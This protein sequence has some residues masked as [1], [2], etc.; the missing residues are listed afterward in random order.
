MYC[1]DINLLFIH[2]T[3][4]SGTSIKKSLREKYKVENIAGINQH[5]RTALSYSKE[6]DLNNIDTVSI[7]RNPYDRYMSYLNFAHNKEWFNGNNFHFM[8]PQYEY[9]YSKD[10]CLVNDILKF[11]DRE[12]INN[13][14][15]KYDIKIYKH[16]IS[17]NKKYEY[18]N[19]D[20]IAFCNKMYDKDFKLFNYERIQL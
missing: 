1:K 18:L 9:L 15:N 19:E 8:R 17:E 6:L 2:I 12:E 7:V 13:Y 20:Q 4:T 3:K 11:E 14:F 5:H 10:G 16:N